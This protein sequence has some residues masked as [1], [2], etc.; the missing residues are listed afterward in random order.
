MANK[1]KDVKTRPAGIN[2]NFEI[3]VMNINNIVENNKTV[4]KASGVKIPNLST[5]LQ[6]G[7]SI[8]AYEGGK[9]QGVER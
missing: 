4:L 1:S 9:A 8:K 7:M 3:A 2:D 6:Q 5:E